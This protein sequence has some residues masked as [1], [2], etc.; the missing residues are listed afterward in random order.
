MRYDQYIL[1]KLVNNAIIFLTPYFKISQSELL[2]FPKPKIKRSV[3]REDRSSYNELNII[4]FK[5]EGIEEYDLGHEVG[6]YFHSMLTKRM[7]GFSTTELSECIAEYAELI[8][9]YKR[10][11]II[12]PPIKLSEL[13]RL[14]PPRDTNYLKSKIEI[15]HL[16]IIVKSELEKLRY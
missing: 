6:H 11:P 8:Y 7:S 15:S 10:D 9:C 16:R 12:N 1:E 3:L 4:L 13:A 14:S 2:E 5:W